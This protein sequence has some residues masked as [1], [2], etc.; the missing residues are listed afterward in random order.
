MTALLVILTLSAA[1]WLFLVISPRHRGTFATRLDAE[2]ARPGELRAWP[3]VTV[4]IPARNEAAMLPTTIPTICTQDYPDVRVIVIDDQSEDDSSAVLASL[5]AAHTNLEVVPGALRPDG[6]CGKPWAVKQGVLAATTDLLLFTDADCAF[7]P[8]A[9]K[10][11]VRFLEDSSLDMVSVFPQMVFGSLIEEIGLAGFLSGLAMVYPTPQANDPKSPMALAAGGFILI[12]RDAY[13]RIGGHEAVKNEMIEDVNLAKKL[14]ES[15]ARIHCRLTRDLV[16]TRMYEGFD[17]LWE[18]LAKN[19]YATVQY[20]P[21]RFWIG[22]VWATIG[23]VLPP[24]YFVLALVIA[25]RHPT[26]QSRTAV[27]LSAVI[28]ISMSIVRARV[29]RH[30]R[31]APWQSF[32]TPVSSGL[33]CLIGASSFWRHHFGR[34]NVW[35]GRTYS[36]ANLN[37]AAVDAALPA[38]P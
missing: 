21:S 15:G 25:L 11:A 31:L 26:W 1:F 13:E 36:R 22:L 28:L 33:Y 4:V 38:K 9:V 14:K 34:G 24:F 27:T 5:R 10:T 16:S 8:R 17:D 2:D 18:G 30:L 37:V 23:M 6:W 3:A 7:H 35:K 12:K 19:V 29:V 20:R 32:L